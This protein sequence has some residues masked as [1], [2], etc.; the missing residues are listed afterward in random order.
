MILKTDKILKEC[1]NWIEWLR[2]KV[3][4]SLLSLNKMHLN[5]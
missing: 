4:L 3:K 5:T 2:L 1:I